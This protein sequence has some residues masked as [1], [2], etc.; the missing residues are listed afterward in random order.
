MSEKEEPYQKNPYHENQNMGL[1][2]FNI[3]F[4]NHPSFY[5]QSLGYG[6]FDDPSYMS[7]TECL[8]GSMD[9]G[10]LSRAFDM[11]CSSS[12]VINSGDVV[13]NVLVESSGHGGNPLTPNSSVSSSSTEAAGEDDSGRGK[14]DQ[15]IK[16]SEDGVDKSKKVNKPRKKGEKRQREPRF[17]FMTESEVDHL[18]DGYRWRKYG[19]KAVKNSPYPRSYYRCTSQK[20]LVK[21]RV[22]R[23]YQDPKIV[24]TTY[25]GQHTH[26]YPA[27]LRGNAASI[28]APSAVFSTPAMPNFHQELMMQIPQ[29]NIQNDHTTSFYQQN[30]TPLQQ[31]QLPDY[32][33]LQDIIPS[34]VHRQP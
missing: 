15:L 7:F 8:Q 25:E 3:P 24:I 22:E 28:L 6:G 26:Q 27:T 20:C 23:S 18:E 12:E 30:L 32:G 5:N 31:L 11:P 17:A 33:L 4:S 10:V 2:N 13:G 21:K 16:A 29:T 19:Q 9:Y 1:S 14:K 34:F